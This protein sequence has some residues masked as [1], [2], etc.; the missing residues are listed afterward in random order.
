MWVVDNNTPFAVERGFLRDRR[1]GEVW[2]VVIKG[3]FDV[4]QDGSA[5]LAEEQEP[6]ARVASWSGEPGKSS[7]LQDSDFILTKAGT[8]V[9]V[10]GHAYAPKGRETQSVEVALRVGTLV[11]RIRVHGLRVWMKGPMSSN[12]V[13]SPARP[14][15]KVA[16]SYENAFGGSDSE[17]PK[18]APLCCARN[19]VGRG[20]RHDPKLLLHQAAPQLET[21]EGSLRAGPYDAIPAGFGPI[22]PGWMP[23]TSLAGTYDKSWEEN[24]APLLPKDFNERFYRT[25]PADQQLSGFMPAG[26]VM[27]L[28]NMTPEQFWRVRAPDL[29]FKMRV[30]FTDGEEQAAAVLHTVMLDP[31]KRRVQFVWQASLPCHGREHRLSRAI[32]NCQGARTC[33]LP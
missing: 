23:R 9:L 8:D 18:G 6:P 17:G 25:A 29:A 19:P 11:K 1:G 5:R 32:V 4:R 31:D 15:V 16:L 10:R 14:F 24:E 12:I 7:L 20:F 2:I 27:E 3:T 33:L 28:V 13:P 22:A 21:I 30:V 26:Q